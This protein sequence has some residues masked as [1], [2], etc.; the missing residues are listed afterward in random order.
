MLKTEIQGL[1]SDNKV[2]CRIRAQAFSG[3]GDW[4]ELVV[5]TLPPKDDDGDELNF[6]EFKTLLCRMANAKIPASLRGGVLLHGG[7]WRPEAVLFN[8]I[9]DERKAELAKPAAPSNGGNR[10]N[11]PPSTT[12]KRTPRT[13]IVCSA[14]RVEEVEES[15]KATRLPYSKSK[16]ASAYTRA[17]WPRLVYATHH[18]ESKINL[19][20]YD[21]L[22]VFHATDRGA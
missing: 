18:K 15:I 13:L 6:S 12:F 2:L 10:S 11:N 3:W 7:G 14:S 9:A 19:V 8:H 4:S 21:C 1:R 17:F 5:S 20:R 22:G 16:G